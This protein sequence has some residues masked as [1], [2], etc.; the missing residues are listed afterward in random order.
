M[1]RLKVKPK[2]GAGEIMSKEPFR[3]V[4]P[5]PSGRG[6]GSRTPLQPW[7][8]AESYLYYTQADFMRQF[9]VSGHRINNPF[10]PDYRDKV[11]VVERTDPKTGET[12]TKKYFQPMIRI[13]VPFQRMIT[14]K[15]L[16]AITGNNISQQMS[17]ED[18]GAE[19]ERTFYSYL[20]G[21]KDKSMEIAWYF[22]AKSCLVTADAAF[23]GW[24]KDGV[25]GW[26]VFSYLNGDTLY[27][28]YDITGRLDAFGRAYRVY[29]AKGRSYRRIL[30]VWD[31]RYVHHYEY[32]ERGLQ[33]LINSVLDWATGDGAWRYTGSDIHGFDR[34]PIAYH[35][36]PYP[37]WTPVQSTIEQFESAISRLA[38]NNKAYALR[39]LFTK[40]AALAMESTVDGTPYQINTEETDA[41]ARFLEPADMSG[42]MKTEIDILEDS[43]YRGSFTVKTPDVRGSDLSG[44][45]V[46][47]LFT[48]SNQQAHCDAQELKPF[49]DD[50]SRIFGYGMARETGQTALAEL[51]VFNEIIPFMPKSETEEVS[52][53][54]QLVGS[55]VLSRRSGS[56]MGTSLGYGRT[57]EWL[58]IQREEREMLIGQAGGNA[59]QNKDGDGAGQKTEGGAEA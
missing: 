43:I 50:M 56:E 20:K 31:D 38:E 29:D 23:C 16:T 4:L 34:I 28:H 6:D 2:Y 44:L 53:I 41:D 49:V 3:T 10:D 42:S 27:P 15:R 21:W 8:A 26:R 57:S 51:D 19:A 22:A 59:N 7:D 35:R 13:A 12:Y 25:F 5:S 1:E 55:G 17:A 47:L 32:G 24:L 54:V 33:G 39:I 30:D 40:G 9:E 18:M 11:K 14:T 52:N 48:D 36:S 58:R 46:E 45:A 37:C